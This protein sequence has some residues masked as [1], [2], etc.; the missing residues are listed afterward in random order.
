MGPLILQIAQAYT[1][2]GSVVAA[3]FVLWGVERVAP[4][5]RGAWTFRPLIVPGVILLWPLVLWR[6]R[7]LARGEDA[8]RRHRPPRR[9]QHLI[10]LALAVAVPVLLATGVLLRQDGPQE[11]PAVPLARAATDAGKAVSP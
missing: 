9:A 8:C 3:V 7:V 4:G 11:R 6:W 5:A 1:L 2:L 10:A